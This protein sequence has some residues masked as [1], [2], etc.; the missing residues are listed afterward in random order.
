MPIHLPEEGEEVTRPTFTFHLDQEKLKK[1]ERR[2][3]HYLL[4]SNLMGEDPSVLWER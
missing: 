3:G 2:D 1:A 4:R